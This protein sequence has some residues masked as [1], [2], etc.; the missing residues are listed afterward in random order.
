MLLLGKQFGSY[1]V[2]LFE[3]RRRSMSFASLPLTAA[4]IL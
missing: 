4:S 1:P 3:D 2:V